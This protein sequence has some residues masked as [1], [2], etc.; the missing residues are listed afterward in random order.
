MYRVKNEI[1]FFPR[2]IITIVMHIHL[3]VALFIHT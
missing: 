3:S 1:E 2:V